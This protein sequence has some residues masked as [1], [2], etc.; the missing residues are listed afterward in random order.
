MRGV[1]FVPGAAPAGRALAKDPPAYT[2]L[3][4][5][6]WV[7]TTPSICTVGSASAV[8]LELPICSTGPGPVGVAAEAAGATATGIASDSTTAVAE[9]MAVISRR[10][11]C[12]GKGIFSWLWLWRCAEGPADQPALPLNS[13]TGVPLE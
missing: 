10:Q 12:L 4:T 2:V 8:T 6:T 13:T 9:L 7:H 11:G 5:I 1:R 3:P